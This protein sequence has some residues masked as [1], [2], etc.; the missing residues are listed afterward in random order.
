MIA[1]IIFAVFLVLGMPALLVLAV[2]WIRSFAELL[3]L[4]TV[5]PRIIAASALLVLSINGAALR[6]LFSL[7]PM[8]PLAFSLS[9]VLIPFVAVPLG[10]YIAYRRRAQ[11]Y[12]QLGWHSFIF[13]ARRLQRRRSY[14][15]PR[16]EQD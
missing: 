16:S 5:R 9:L 2:H 10:N 7:P 14:E 15:A 3:W 1:D 11:E 13:D 8:G 12:A 6:V 4:L